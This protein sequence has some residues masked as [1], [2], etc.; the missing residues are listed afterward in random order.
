MTAEQAGQGIKDAVLGRVRQHAGEADTA[1]ARLREIES[2]PK[3]LKTVTIT[4]RG[5]VAGR[6]SVPVQT[7]Q[8]IALPV[9]LRGVKRSLQPIYDELV[10]RYPIA[11]QE[12]SAA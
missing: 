2:D 3:N 5:Q 7:Q 8:S 11:Q 1:Y 4:E 9:D 10:R 6:G 12:A